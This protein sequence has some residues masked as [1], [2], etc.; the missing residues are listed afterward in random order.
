MKTSVFY[1]RKA[2]GKQ[3]PILTASFYNCLIYIYIYIQYRFFIAK[4]RR[5]STPHPLSSDDEDMP[6]VGK[7]KRK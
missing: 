4:R 1:K 5:K 3:K 7:N 2:K 6:E